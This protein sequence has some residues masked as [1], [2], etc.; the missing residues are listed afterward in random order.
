MNGD[1]P[2]LVT[3]SMRLKARR[4]GAFP[5]GMAQIATLRCRR[6]LNL[7]TRSSRARGAMVVEF[8]MQPWADL[9]VGRVIDAR[10][11]AAVLQ[12]ILVEGTAL[13]PVVGYDP[14]LHRIDA[15]FQLEFG[16]GSDLEDRGDEALDAG[17]ERE[18]RRI[19]DHALARVGLVAHKWGVYVLDRNDD[20]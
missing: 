1:R 16:D 20:P 5:G 6:C 14:M 19:L 12:A 3:R 9:E 15:I 17:A 2:S 8:S 11:L 7:S 18:A 10:D 13:E 4:A